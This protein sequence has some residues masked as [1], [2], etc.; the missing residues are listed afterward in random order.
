MKWEPRYSITPEL[1]EKIKRIY[2]LVQE[3]NGRKFS[4]IVLVEF[5]HSARE[6]SA[7]ASTSI[8]GNP[9]PLTEVKKILKSRPEVMRDSE[10]EV[11]NYN[12]ALVWLARELNKKQTGLTVGQILKIH[13]MVTGELLPSYATGRWRKKPVVVNDP[14][15]RQVVYL[16]PD[17]QKVPDLIEEMTNFVNQG[18]GRIDPVIMAGIVHK[19]LVIIHPFLD[20]NGRTTRLVTKM[21]LAAM[22][23]DTF[24]LFSFENYYN[25]NVSRYFKT[26]G[27]YGDYE[28]LEDKIDFTAWLTYF[29]DGI[30]DELLRV[31]KLL[32]VS[33]LQPAKLAPQHEVILQWVRERGTINDREYSKL[34][35]RAKATRVID[36]NYL[37]KVG[38]IRREGKGKNTFYVLA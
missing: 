15:S 2:A 32:G 8:E 3:L 12:Q 24:N 17:W 23:L 31:Q 6:L 36:F 21:L 7:H 9:L 29:A 27:E 19:Q 28:E 38:L 1:L 22:G 33:G 18:W 10:R 13:E 14:V 4:Q 25:Q 35:E 16:P 37:I 5:A 20:G 30:I 34:T 26:V 11:I